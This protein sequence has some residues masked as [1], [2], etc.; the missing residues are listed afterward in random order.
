MATIKPHRIC[1]SNKYRTVVAKL[2]KHLLAKTGIHLSYKKAREIAIRNGLIPGVLHDSVATE[3][4]I[5]VGRVAVGRL[6][7]TENLLNKE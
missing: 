1:M 6:C 7:P 5:A 4:D 2:K 3:S